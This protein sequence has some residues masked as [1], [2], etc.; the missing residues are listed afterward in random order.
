MKAFNLLDVLLRKMGFTVTIDEQIADAEAT[1]VNVFKRD[2]NV[3]IK[4][5]R[6]KKGGTMVNV[7]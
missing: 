4:R 3:R 5:Q 7:F 2:A 6:V 1:V